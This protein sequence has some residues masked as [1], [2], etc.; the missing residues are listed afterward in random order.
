MAESCVFCGA[1]LNW[2]GKEFLNCG[3]VTQPVCKD[4]LNKYRGTSQL[5]RCQDALKTGRAVE[6][7]R[8]RAFLEDEDS[9]VAKQRAEMEQ[10][11]QVMRC[12]DQPMTPLGISEFQ[13]GRESF[14][15]GSWSNL[16]SGAMELGVFR[17]EC[18]GQ[19]KF[20]DPQFMKAKKG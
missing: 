12:C 14:L 4:C 16:V 19:V 18:C 6:P 10:L 20:M 3:G 5:V 11:G 2:F 1:E 13:L 15:L 17:C 7:E 9:E 8:I